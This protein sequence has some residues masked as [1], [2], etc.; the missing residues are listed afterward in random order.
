MGQ[1]YDEVF[2]LHSLSKPDSLLDSRQPEARRP[3][4][5]ISNANCHWR[6]TNS[7]RDYSTVSTRYLSLQVI[8][9]LGIVGPERALETTWNS[10]SAESG[11]AA[12]PAVPARSPGLRAALRGLC[13]RSEER[14][15]GKECRSRW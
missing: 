3:G 4:G 12:Q 9:T 13:H 1:Y 15:V 11:G 14:R 5:A 8:D 2:L 7:N 10:F 6:I